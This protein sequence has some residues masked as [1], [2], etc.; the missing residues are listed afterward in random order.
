M[1]P[2]RSCIEWEEI[3]LGKLKHNFS[4]FVLQM[5]VDQAINDVRNDRKS[6]VAAIDELYI[7]CS[8]YEK[9]VRKD[10]DRIFNS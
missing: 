6:T 7:L 10:L 8:K 5:K 2:D 3:V 1:I 9:A 4:N